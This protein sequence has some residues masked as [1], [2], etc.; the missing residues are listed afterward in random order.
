MALNESCVEIKLKIQR[1]GIENICNCYLI[2][3]VCMY[4]QTKLFKLEN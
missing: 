2:E 3:L 4:I 1:W